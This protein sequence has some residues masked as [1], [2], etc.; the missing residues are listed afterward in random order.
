M[1]MLLLLSAL[2]MLLRLLILIKSSTSFPN[3]LRSSFA[4]LTVV[5]IDIVFLKMLCI[6][7]SEW[8]TVSGYKKLTMGTMNAFL[9]REV[10]ERKESREKILTLRR[11]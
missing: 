9:A 4:T 11:K 8:Y 2:F 1:L 5:N 10:S 7:S 3:H 6:S